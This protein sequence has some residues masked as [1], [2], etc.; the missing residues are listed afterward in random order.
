MMNV[1]IGKKSNLTR[2]IPKNS[3]INKS[4]KKEKDANKNT[5]NRTDKDTF[6]PAL[7]HGVYNSQ[8]SH[9]AG[10]THDKKTNIASGTTDDD[11]V[12][13]HLPGVSP[14]LSEIDIK[15]MERVEPENKH[16]INMPRCADNDEEKKEVDNKSGE[17]VETDTNGASKTQLSNEAADR[18]LAG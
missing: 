11:D 1:E 8:D 5:R 9:S 4:R 13:S 3:G 10:T 15:K 16:I 14:K 17:D 12:V 7:D 18:F 6:N 2:T